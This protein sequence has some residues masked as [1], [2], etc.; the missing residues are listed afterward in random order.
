MILFCRRL[1]VLRGQ[2]QR[3]HQREAGLRQAGR[4][5]LWEDER[6]RQRC[7]QPLIQ[8]QRWQPEGEAPHQSG[9]LRMLM[10]AVLETRSHHK[11]SRNLSYYCDTVC[12]SL[13][14]LSSL[15]HFSIQW[16]LCICSYF[17]ATLRCQRAAA[18][19]FIYFFLHHFPFLI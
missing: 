14:V 6:E 5:Y 4:R 11:Q 16:G 12:L 10:V 1:P 8:S 9:G 17:I 19:P 3:Q 13:S 15:H 7:C 18:A 2:R